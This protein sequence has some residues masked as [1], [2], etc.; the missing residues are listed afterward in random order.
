MSIFDSLKKLVARRDSTVIRSG[1]M[2]QLK[3]Q[4]SILET[5]STMLAGDNERLKTEN[6]QLK[7]QLE[8]ARAE[9]KRFKQK[10][11]DVKKLMPEELWILKFLFNN[12]RDHVDGDTVMQKLNIDEGR[13]D[14]LLGRLIESGY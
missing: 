14:Y 4:I 6:Q 7:T 8:N 1:Q 3:E 5:K 12:T 9:I 10:D 2:T 11:E 13:A